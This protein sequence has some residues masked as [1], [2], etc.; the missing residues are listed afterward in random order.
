M[1][2]LLRA[3]IAVCGLLLSALPSAADDA[4]TKQLTRIA[5]DSLLV[6][7]SAEAAAKA[8]ELPEDRLPTGLVELDRFLIRHEIADGKRVVRGRVIRHPEKFRKVGLDRLYTLKLP[9]SDP[10]LVR[11][12][13][14]ELSRSP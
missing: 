7:L 14:A 4:E 5:G 10:K 11:A 13:V 1:G 6:K 3:S 9:R 2:R 8:R 12:L